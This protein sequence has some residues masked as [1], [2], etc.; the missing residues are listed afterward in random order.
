MFHRRRFDPCRKIYKAWFSLDA[1]ISRSKDRDNRSNRKMQRSV[2]HK[3]R[4]KHKHEHEHKHKHEERKTEPKQKTFKKNHFALRQHHASRITSPVASTF[5]QAL[6][7]SSFAVSQYPPRFQVS[8]WCPK[9]P[10]TI[11]IKLCQN[12]NALGTL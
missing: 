4:H 1:S 9:N 10:K 8:T 12:L 5:S 6:A 11:E 3:H 2:Q 7:H